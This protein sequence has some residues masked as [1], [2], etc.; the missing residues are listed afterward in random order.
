MVKLVYFA[1]VRERIGKAE[2]Q[3]ELP[4]GVT[5]VADLIAWLRTR[6]PEYDSAFAKPGVIRAAIDRAHVKAD[7]QHCRRRRDR[8]LPT[9]HGRLTWR[10]ASRPR[11]STSA[12]R[13]AV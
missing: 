11:T 4:A 8:L 12:P 3:V 10:F 13:S 2:E 9:C 7:R 6:G 1:W 5:T